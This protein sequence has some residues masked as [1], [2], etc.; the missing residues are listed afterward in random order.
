M[1]V[2]GDKGNQEVPPGLKKD[3]R[4]FIYCMKKK[5]AMLADTGSS[6][7]VVPRDPKLHKEIDP[8][9]RIKGANNKPIPVYAIHRYTF[10]FGD[11]TIR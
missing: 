4:P 2:Q 3:L 8:D 1:S 10:R 11:V 6:L 7:C 5:E 9:V